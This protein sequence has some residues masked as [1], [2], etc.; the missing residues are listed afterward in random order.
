MFSSTVTNKFYTK[1]LNR[2]SQSCSSELCFCSTSCT[3]FP[4]LKA[5]STVTICQSHLPDTR[6]SSQIPHLKLQVLIC[7]C[8]HVEANCCGEKKNQMKA[9]YVTLSGIFLSAAIINATFFF[10]YLISVL[11]VCK[12]LK[13]A[14]RRKTAHLED[15]LGDNKFAEYNLF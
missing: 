15:N 8:L 4:H 13:G 12:I 2:Q 10:F 7:D 5:I 6:L 14:I 3:V 11:R 9:E 1:N